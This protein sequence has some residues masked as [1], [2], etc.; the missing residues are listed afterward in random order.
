MK[1][2]KTKNRSPDPLSPSPNSKGKGNGNDKFKKQKRDSSPSFFGVSRNVE[3]EVMTIGSPES[4]FKQ[5]VPIDPVP[6]NVQSEV[7]VDTEPSMEIEPIMSKREKFINSQLSNKYSR[8]NT[9]PFS[10]LVESLSTDNDA[11]SNI[12]NLHFMKIGKMLNGKF[13]S[14]TSI[15]RRGR[16]CININFSSYAEANKLTESKNLFHHNCKIYIPNFKIYRTGVIRDVEKS[17]SNDEIIQ[18]ITWPDSEAKIINIERLK[19]KDKNGLLQNSSSIKMV[20]ESNLI[21]EYLYIWN[22]RCRVFP[23]ADGVTPSP[24]AGATNLVINAVRIMIA[25]IVTI[26]CSNV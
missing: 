11:Y 20:F 4:S 24:F 1:K 23:I 19:F 8:F 10:V 9:A 17:L 18:G 21:P 13:K 12:G 7:T 22:V 6:Y 16:S 5:N 3:S 25:R 2:S 15:K 14:I 26:L